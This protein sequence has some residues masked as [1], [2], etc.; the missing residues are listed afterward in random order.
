MYVCMSVCL[1][2][3]LS[4]YLSVFGF[5]L[6]FVEVL[7]PHRHCID[8]IGGGLRPCLS[9][10]TRAVWDSTSQQKNR[11]SRE[12]PTTRRCQGS[13]P[14]FLRATAKRLAA[15]AMEQ[16][17]LTPTPQAPVLRFVFNFDCEDCQAGKALVEK[18][19]THRHTFS[20]RKKGKICKILSTE[21]HGK[22]DNKIKGEELLA[23]ICR[24]RHPKPS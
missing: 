3:C 14:R 2:V 20:C 22:L 19:Q 13:N 23:P 8:H 24:L 21:G 15:R 17:L 12:Q 5:C 1:S 10:P 9:G 4:V 6:V 16:T 7:R 18:F 11:D